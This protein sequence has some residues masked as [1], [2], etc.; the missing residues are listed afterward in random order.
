MLVSIVT[1]VRN[2]ADTIGSAVESLQAQRWTQWEHVV[3]DAS[4]TDGTLEVLART[5]D[6]RTRIESA[7]DGGMYDALNRAF[8]RAGGEI[9]GLLHSDDLFAGPD[10]L[11][12]VVEVFQ[13]PSVDAV[14]GNLLYVAR[15]DPTRVIRTWKSRPFRPALLR[16]GWM[17]AH[18]TLF[19]RRRVIERFGVFDTSYKIAADYDAVLRYFSQPDFRPVHVPKIFVHM[20]MGGESN[21]SVERIL[22]KSIEDYRALRSHKV[23]G[24]G[25]LLLK[26]ASKIGQFF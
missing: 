25:S 4:S 3:Q 22:K 11:E 8:V 20:R 24:A 16:R 12:T 13:D 1:A 9:V 2:R 10:V 17:P 5:A 15:D 26:N 23:G 18:P 19:L 6:R 7:R 14:Y 21:R